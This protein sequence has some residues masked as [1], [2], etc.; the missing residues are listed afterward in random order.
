MQSADPSSRDRLLDVALE[1]FASRG[2]AATS[3]AEIQK[4]SG[5]S[6]GSGALYRHFRSKNEV[7]RAA[8]RRGLDRMRDSRAWRQATTPADRLEALNRVADAAH[9]T[10]IENADLVR[11]MLHEPD[12]AR[13]LVDELWMRNLAFA[14]TTMGHTLRVTA[15]ENGSEVEDPEAISAVLLAALSYMPIMQV[16]LGRPPGEMDPDRFRDAWLR[17][18]RAV[19][20]HGV[21]T[22]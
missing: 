5:M 14:Y 19:F 11:L 10:V 1:L 20:T 18:S 2:Y 12:A 4:A 22:D 8:L 9:Q 16:L 17:L 3:T 21:P 15:N 6:P 13:D 7:L